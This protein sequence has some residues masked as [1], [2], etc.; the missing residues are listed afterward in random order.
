MEHRAAAARRPGRSRDRVLGSTYAELALVP[1]AEEDS[2]VGHLGPDL[3]GADWDVDEAV[4][5]L[6][7][8]PE[9]AIG[10]ALVDQRNLASSR[11][12]VPTLRD[13]AAP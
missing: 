11:P 5:R 10:E 2:V 9:R 13:D 12:A 3:L 1:T 4:R 7:S 8:R 6:R